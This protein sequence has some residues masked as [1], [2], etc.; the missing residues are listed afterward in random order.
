MVLHEDHIGLG[1]LFIAVE[2]KGYL[3]MDAQEHVKL[4]EKGAG[5]RIQPGLIDCDLYMKL[6]VFREGDMRERFSQEQAQVKR[7]E[8]LE[9]LV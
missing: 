1:K 3:V 9:R 5:V 7:A 4:L 8:D 6:P 2:V